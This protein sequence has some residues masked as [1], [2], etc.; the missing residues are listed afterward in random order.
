MPLKTSAACF[1]FF[2]LVRLIAFALAALVFPAAA[3]PAL[4]RPNVIVVLLDDA[5]YGDFSHTGNP[6][7]HTPNL[8][9]MVAEG[10]NFPQFYAAAAACSA[11]RYGLLTGRHPLRSG[12]GSWAIG[13][14]AKRHI[15]PRETTLAE[16][17]KQRG[18]ATAMFGKWHLG[19]PNAANSHTPDAFPLA[20]GFDRWLGTNV[21]ND[22]NPGSILIQGP[23]EKNEP[24]VGYEILER[25]IATKVPVQESLTGRYADAAVDFIRE[26]KDL[27]FFIY[28]APNM[29]HLPVHASAAF[30]GKSPRGPYGDCIQEIDHHLGRVRDALVEAGIEKNTLLIFTSDNGPWIRFQDTPKHPLYQEARTLIGSALPF[31]D[32]KGST[33]EGGTRVAGVW[34]WPGT[35]PAGTVVPGPASTL[36][37]L[38]TAFA[39]AAEALP[40][41]RTLDGRDLRPLINHDAFPGS[42]PEFRYH[43]A[44]SDTLTGVRAGPWKLHTRLVSQTGSDHGFSASEEK[45]LLFQLEHDASERIDRAMEQPGKV[46]KGLA[47]FQDFKES[48]ATEGSYWDAAG[49]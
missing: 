6:V 18:Y 20:H 28:L 32:G 31:R 8:S 5:G 47:M 17:L 46:K 14:D 44:S 15:H 38:P 11:S 36:D 27:P 34:W 39:L 7:I 13:P 23:S 29:P 49:Q 25:D 2:T 35:I 42:V 45:P 16:G 48:L 21:S 22:Y 41:G 33:W 24:A 9:R 12:L 26:K 40:T 43:F 10:A 3:R 1:R 4:E 37:V 30:K 19:T